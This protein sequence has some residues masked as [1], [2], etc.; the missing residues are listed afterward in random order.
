MKTMITIGSTIIDQVTVMV[1]PVDF[2]TDLLMKT[3]TP[4]DT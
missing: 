2:Y 1:I 3:P 4:E